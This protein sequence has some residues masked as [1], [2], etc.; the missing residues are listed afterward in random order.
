MKMLSMLSFVLHLAAAASAAPATMR[1]YVATSPNC[2]TQGFNATFPVPQL[3]DLHRLYSGLPP[4]SLCE[5]LVRVEASSVN[6]SD[7]HPTVAP[8]A[9]PHVMGSDV[10]GVVVATS[11]GAACSGVH[12]GR[13]NVGDRVFGDIGANTLTSGGVKTKELGGY[14]E[15]AVALASQLG[16]VPSNI[17]FAEAAAL[18]K[19]RGWGAVAS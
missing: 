6:P 2:A 7:V 17:G 19:V 10:S 1:A 4:S 18:P 13:I 12:K 8:G 15:Y 3:G 14:G 11:G 9:A 16:V 5:C